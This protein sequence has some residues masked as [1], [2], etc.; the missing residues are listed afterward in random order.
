MTRPLVV[1]T[2]RLVCTAAVFLSLASAR[3]AALA[4]D[5]PPSISGIAVSSQ[6]Q[7]Q[8]A[9]AAWRHAR[10][11]DRP[12][13]PFLVPDAMPVQAGSLPLNSLSTLSN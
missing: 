9:L 1:V 12:D 11:L 2:A 4:P 13:K 5:S 3:A 6:A 10:G 8:R 7:P